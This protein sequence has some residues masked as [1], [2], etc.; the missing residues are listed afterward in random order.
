MDKQKGLYYGKAPKDD[1]LITPVYG[2]PMTQRLFCK[3]LVPPEAP[4][5][6]FAFVPPFGVVFQ[7]EAGDFE[8]FNDSFIACPRP[9]WWQRLKI[10]YKIWR[11][12][13]KIRKALVAR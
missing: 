5:W 8:L 9:N 6:Y 11:L 4:V 7:L 13:R 2:R 1:D 3:S 12:R 10:R